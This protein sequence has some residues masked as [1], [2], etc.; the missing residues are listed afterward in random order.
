M[1]GPALRQAEDLLSSALDA[2][3]AARLCACISDAGASA[4]GGPA[5]AAAEAAV[6]ALAAMAHGPAVRMT[7]ANWLEHFPAAQALS[8]KVRGARARP[9]RW[10]RAASA[11]AP[12]PLARPAAGLGRCG[13]AVVQSRATPPCWDSL[14]FAPLIS[15]DRQ[16][17]QAQDRGLDT[18]DALCDGARAA[19]ASALAAS[20]AALGAL[21]AWARARRPGAAPATGGAEKRDPCIASLLVLHH[22]CRASP[23]LSE[24]V[25]ASGAHEALLEA[26][27]AGAERSGGGGGGGGGAAAALAGLALAS[28]VAG[29]AARSGGGGG[30]SAAAAAAIALAPSALTDAAICRLAGGCRGVG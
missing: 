1:R 17:T 6:W 4:P 30:G 27:T 9:R 8:S 15:P 7:S 19:A 22:C 28:A 10:G 11:L 13:L 12:S 24:A 29:V 20:P 21:A 2:S 14:L 26:A 3:L 18:D 16:P 25:V 5:A 23:E